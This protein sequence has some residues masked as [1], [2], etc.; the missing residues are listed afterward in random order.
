M[1]KTKVFLFGSVVK[2]KTEP[3]SDIYL[4]IISPKL[5]DA[6]TKSEIRT[7]ILRKIG[8]DSPFEIHLA[9]PEEYD[10]WYKFFIKRNKIQV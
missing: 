2:N 3:G 1:G 5:K 4:L 7:K 6:E 9:T 10:Q 8:T